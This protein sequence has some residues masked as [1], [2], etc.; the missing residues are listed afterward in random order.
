DSDGEAAPAGLHAGRDCRPRAARRADGASSPQAS[1]GTVTTA[2]PGYRG[3]RRP[4]ARWHVRAAFPDP[5]KSFAAIHT[6]CRR[7]WRP[8]TSWSSRRRSITLAVRGMTPA[9]GASKGVTSRPW[10][11]PRAGV[12]GFRAI[13]WNLQ[14][15]SPFSSN[16]VQL[17]RGEGRLERRPLRRRTRSQ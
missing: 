11:A 6:N 14:A 10:L 3:L 5:W 12:A 1:E 16:A 17:V 8:R 4:V 13:S 9:G 7:R 2:L 15:S